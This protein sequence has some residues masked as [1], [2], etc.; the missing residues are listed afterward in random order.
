MSVECGFQG[1][2]LTTQ[3]YG[4]VRRQQQLVSLYEVAPDYDFTFEMTGFTSAHRVKVINL[5]IGRTSSHSYLHS[6]LLQSHHQR[7]ICRFAL[8]CLQVPP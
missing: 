7:G 4:T 8:R 3:V 1:G 2:S 6:S 5:K